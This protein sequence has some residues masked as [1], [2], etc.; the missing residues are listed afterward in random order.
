MNSLDALSKMVSQYPGGRAAIA[1]RMGWSLDVLNQKFST[2]SAHKMGLLEAEEIARLC[3]EVEVPDAYALAS[4]FA[5]NSGYLLVIPTE[6][7][8]GCIHS[9]AAKAVHE[10]ADVL[11]AV[12]HAR[13]DGHTSDN[14]KKNVLT[15]ILQLV[16]QAQQIASHITSQNVA[17]NA[18]R[19]TVAH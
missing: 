7:L 11:S 18:R 4:T 2:K 16:A 8:H 5:F 9:A 15:E 14:D 6:G 17:D 1:A 13:A 3:K 19:N 10:V 12:N